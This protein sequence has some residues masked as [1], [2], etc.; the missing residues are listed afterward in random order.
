MEVGVTLETGDNAV[1]VVEMDS[2][3]VPAPAPIPL[4]QVMEQNVQDLTKRLE[5]VITDH[6]LVGGTEWT[7]LF[8]FIYQRS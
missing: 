4:R 6:A 8:S 1:L 2:K 3:N 7:Q 5:L